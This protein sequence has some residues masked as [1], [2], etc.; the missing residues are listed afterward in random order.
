MEKESKDDDT[1]FKTITYDIAFT[2]YALG[3]TN[4]LWQ[5]RFYKENTDEYLNEVRIIVND[6]SSS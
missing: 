6:L 4:I 5:N 3:L 1:L 2:E